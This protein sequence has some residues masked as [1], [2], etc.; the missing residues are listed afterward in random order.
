DCQR[1][2][3]YSGQSCNTLGHLSS[4]DDW[5]GGVRRRRG[6]NDD[7]KRVLARIAVVQATGWFSD[8]FFE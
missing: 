6:I 5:A 1:A 4:P 7:A 8:G 2:E 3:G